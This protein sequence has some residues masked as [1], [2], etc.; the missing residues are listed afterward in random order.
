[1][2]IRWSTIVAA[3]WLLG[4]V[5]LVSA[6]SI[7]ISSTNLKAAYNETTSKLMVSLIAG[8]QGSIV[9]NGD[10]NGD[11]GFLTS[12]LVFSATAGYAPSGPV[13]ATAAT[14]DLTL[15]N[16]A[17]LHADSG[18]GTVNYGGATTTSSFSFSKFTLNSV[19]QESALTFWFNRSGT[20]PTS[21]NGTSTLNNVTADTEFSG[22]VPTGVPLPGVA[23]GGMTLLCG[24]F[25]KRCL[26][27]GTPST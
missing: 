27:R 13:A 2:S 21:L 17:V 4:V 18:S 15:D 5:N 24:L 20:I 19:L 7:D 26:S 23:W 16:G 3:L 25:G 6:E 12:S 14:L 8:P 1:M 10:D 9:I 22:P 11:P